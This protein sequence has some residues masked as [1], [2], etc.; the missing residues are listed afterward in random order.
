MSSIDI[1]GKNR[2]ILCRYMNIIAKT[3]TRISN[4][5]FSVASSRVARSAIAL[6]SA[7]SCRPAVSSAKGA[8][9]IQS[10]NPLDLPAAAV[11]P[12]AVRAADID[13]E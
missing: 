1:K 2:R 5:W 12:P 13:Y 10:P 7:S 3:A 9:A 6:M 4:V 8:V 11:P